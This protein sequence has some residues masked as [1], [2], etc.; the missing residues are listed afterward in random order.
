MQVVSA[1]QA[2]AAAVLV[3]NTQATGFMRMSPDPPTPGFET[4]AITVPSA[5]LPRNSA[6]PLFA[7][8]AAGQVGTL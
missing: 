3:A 5:S 1:Q 6:T 4:P 2:G 7:A 8:L